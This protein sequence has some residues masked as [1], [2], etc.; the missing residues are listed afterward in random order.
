MNASSADA[1]DRCLA[2]W[3]LGDPTAGPAASDAAL[4]ELIGRA[5]FHGALP[6]I[7][8]HASALAGIAP[9]ALLDA[10]AS[11]ARA[12]GAFELA[13]RPLIAEVLAA[14]DG[15]GCRPLLLKGAALAHS[16]Y[17]A[18]WQR[19]RSDID[20]LVAP[21]ART[22]AEAALASRGFARAPQLPG[23]LVSYQAT[24]I[25]H[26]DG[27]REHGIDLH[28]RVNNALTLSRLLDH[29]ELVADARQLPVYGPGARSPAP[30]PAL[31]LACIHHAGS[32]DAPYH[33]DAIVEWGGDRLI[34]LYD[35]VLLARA[36]GATDCAESQKRVAAKG[37]QPLLQS[38]FA[39]AARW[40]P[41]AEPDLACLLP[42]GDG[43][44][45]LARY[46]AAGPQGRRWRDFL[47]LDD[48]AARGR[49]LGQLLWPDAAYLRWR[50]PEHAGA[51]PTTLRLRRLAAGAW[52]AL[53]G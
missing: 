18:P 17:A 26:G 52:R 1:I 36:A 51:W 49:F 45:E 29:A 39:T 47:A 41:S 27:G 15:A 34:W 32:R 14:L 53:R 35:L 22:A 37:A 4:V 13:Q 8:S 16:H 10:A 43:D 31:L 38:T 23:D 25:V 48:V 21:D 42:K 2:A 24:W 44:P 33:R 12:F 20:V 7:H 40:F 5:R 19:P 6:L 28:W 46:L 11:E 3:M 9:P 30:A 50:Y